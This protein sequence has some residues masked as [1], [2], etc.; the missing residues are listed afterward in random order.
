MGN[1]G[2]A[3]ELYRNDGQGN[4]AAVVGSAVTS[5]SAPT[6]AVAWGDIDGDGDLVRR[7]KAAAVLSVCRAA[8]DAS[9]WDGRAVLA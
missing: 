5:G 9:R 1:Y 8:C 2:G 4:F 6:S 3:N 7:Q